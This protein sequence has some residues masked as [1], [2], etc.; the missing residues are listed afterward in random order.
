MLGFHPMDNLARRIS[1]LRSIL[2]VAKAMT[3]EREL[4]RLLELVVSE[5]TKVVQ[6]ERSS[7]FIY[8]AER[9]ELWSK[10]AE[11][12]AEIRFSAKTGIAGAVAMTGLVSNIP[13]AWEDPAFNRTFDEQSGFRTKSVLTVPM[14]TT[15]GEV[16]GVLQALNK[17]GNAERFDSEDEE[18]LLALAGVA[19]AAISNTLLH[20]DIERLFEG[21]ASAAVVAIES[22]DPTTAGHSNR[23]AAVSVELARAAEHLATGRWAGLKFDRDQ[24]QELRYA[25]LLHD[26]GKVGVREEVL[27]KA[28][29]LYPGDLN[30][31]EERFE[32]IH[33]TLELQ[34]ARR[35]LDI[36]QRGGEHVREAL[37][38]EDVK[39][40]ARLDELAEMLDFIQASNLPTV[41][42]EGSFER[43]HEI[44]ARTFVDTRGATR[45][46]LTPREVRLLSIRKG[47]L[48]PEERNEIES[49][50]SHTFRFLSQIPWTRS[51]RNVPEIAF[52]HHEKLTGDGYP[53]GLQGEDIL[54]QTRMITIA[55]I[56]DA[57]TAGDRPYKRAMSHERALDILH[58]EAK[59]GLIDRDLLRVFTEADVARRAL[60]PTL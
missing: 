33:R 18:I 43:L 32:T 60:V 52:G 37:R 49:H 9:A 42:A 45:S 22:R 47:S 3:E 35:K 57:L 26:F 46:Y 10:V 59:A 55:D 51:L 7:L 41:S 40:R 17:Q 21:F 31:L 5:T 34:T 2:D 19:G 58:I 48:G 50:V 12:A 25:A 53:R 8:D 15:R 4:D 1:Q 28:N 38:S 11:G 24:M 29:K 14:R 20:E 36:A 6:S 30:A 23:V 16:V 44:A 56:Y 39:L 27:V 54:P 13:D